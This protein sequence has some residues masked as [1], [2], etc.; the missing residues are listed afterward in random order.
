[1]LKKLSQSKLLKYRIFFTNLVVVIDL[2]I[3]KPNFYFYFL[4][5]FLV[6]I[7]ALLRVWASGC[8]HKN[9]FLI[10]E[11][12]YKL[13]RNPLYL[14]SFLSVIGFSFISNKGESIILVLFLF[15]IFYLPT[16]YKEENYLKENF[17]ESFLTYC[18]AVPRFFPNLKSLINLFS[19][20]NNNYNFS[21]AQVKKNREPL[22]FAAMLIAALLGIVKLI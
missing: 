6:L 20:K 15:L 1:M 18:R 19:L 10:K 13:C 9:E 11:G 7:G 5:F 16:I 21:W 3:A 17:Q 4:G 2:I 14:G 12:P 22:T 8:I